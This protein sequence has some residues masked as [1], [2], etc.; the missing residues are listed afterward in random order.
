MARAA[1]AVRPL[2]P[3]DDATPATEHACRRHLPAPL[4]PRPPHPWP[5]PPGA[6]S[7]QPG[8]QRRRGCAA[9]VVTRG[10][11][12]AHT[13]PTS[14]LCSGAASSAAECCR[15]RR[16]AQR[17]CRR[18]RLASLPRRVGR[19]SGPRCTQLPRTATWRLRGC[20]WRRRPTSTRETRSARSREEAGGDG[21]M[22]WEV[23]EGERMRADE[24]RRRSAEEAG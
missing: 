7:P 17:A 20:W 9:A 11:I 5:R 3:D 16:A 4:P 10:L 6:S 8:G 21:W 18:S 13:H 15:R 23:S 19:T 14:A 2:T 12:A 24:H 22:E 1:C